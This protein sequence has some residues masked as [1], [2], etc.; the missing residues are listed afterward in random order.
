MY[1]RTNLQIELRNPC[2]KGK[3][4]LVL[5]IDYTLFDHR[6]TAE[7]PLQL[8]RPCNFC[9]FFVFCFL[10]FTRSVY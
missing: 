7:N 6:S 8:M 4:L 10:F 3:K 9:P 1:I 5:D 2:R